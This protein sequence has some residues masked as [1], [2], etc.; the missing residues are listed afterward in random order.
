MHPII[1]PAAP[2]RSGYLLID[3]SNLDA[4]T[5]T[6][7]P[8]MHSCTPAALTNAADLMPRLIDVRA[9][10]EQQQGDVTQA[11]LREILCDRPPVVCAWLHSALS[12][13]ALA[14]HIARFLIGP[15]SDGQ[16]VFW[17]NYDPRVFSFAL[18]LLSPAQRDALLGPITEWRFAWCRHW[19]SVPGPGR[20]IDMLAGYEAAWPTVAQWASLAHCELILPIL[21]QLQDALSAEEC[22]LYQQKIDRYLLDAR[23]RLH[24]SEK[25]E[26]TDY[27]VHCMRYG[28]DFQHHRKLTAAWAQLTSGEISWSALLS[29]LD[30]ADYRGLNREFPWQQTRKGIPR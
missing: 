23:Q 14:R 15:G 29:L 5:F 10:S 30:S 11:L 26:Q 8:P 7:A 20:A 28:N 2:I 4:Q 6:D 25:S 22:L 18:Y 13:D 1:T 21:M 3:A 16:L 19:W 24:L 9:L 17:R 12:T 27:A